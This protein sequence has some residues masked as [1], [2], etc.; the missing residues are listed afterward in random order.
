M[1]FK[2]EKF[3]VIQG[4]AKFNFR[5]ITTEETYEIITSSKELKIVETVPGWSHNI[6][7]IGSEEMIVYFG[8]MKFLIQ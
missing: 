2:T 7:N 1:P 6:T 5:H 4:K 3:L 8:L